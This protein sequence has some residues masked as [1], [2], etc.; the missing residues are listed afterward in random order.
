MSTHDSLDDRDHGNERA[1]PKALLSQQIHVRRMIA[2]PKDAAKEIV[3]LLLLVA[4]P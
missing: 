1:Y 2:R 3:W 4:N